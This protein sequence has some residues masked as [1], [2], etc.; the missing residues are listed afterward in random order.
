MSLASCV[1]PAARRLPA[2]GLTS[3]AA[4]TYDPT[5]LSLAPWQQQQPNTLVASPHS[6]HSQVSYM[7]G[8]GY[9]WDTDD[10]RLSYPPTSCYPTLSLDSASPY[11]TPDVAPALPFAADFSDAHRSALLDHPNPAPSRSFSALALAQAQASPPSPR[12]GWSSELYAIAPASPASEPRS[13]RVKEEDEEGAFIFEVPVQAAASGPAVAAMPEVP[14]RA[15]Q[16]CGAMRAMMTAFRLDPFAMHNGI[17]GA[18]TAPTCVLEV[19]PLREPPVVFEWQVHLNEPLVPQTPP[20]AP[21]SA[22]PLYGLDEE[23][24]KWAPPE[25]YVPFAQ[26]AAT[27]QHQQQESMEFEPLMTP[28]DSL[29]WSMRYQSSDSP[30]PAYP[31]MPQPQLPVPRPAQTSLAFASRIEQRI[32]AGYGTRAPERADEL[33]RPAH[34]HLHRSA[35]SRQAQ[36][37]GSYAPASGGALGPAGAGAWY[38]KSLSA[39]YAGPDWDVAQQQGEDG[40]RTPP[41]ACPLA[42]RPVW[43]PCSDAGRALC[44][45]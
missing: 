40:T 45:V 28:A 30:S 35:P 27:Q 14:L 38:R 15:T 10:Q 18:A 21:R 3:F 7:S 44:A 19:G 11:S 32:S 8:T 26:A 24:E 4:T 6:Q 31:A 12:A 13:P 41:L 2:S 43:A 36:A 1:A 25:E 16:A 42:R 23:D 29:D 17:R 9:S 33:Y 39:S 22:S 5:S 34:T 37:Y 20:W